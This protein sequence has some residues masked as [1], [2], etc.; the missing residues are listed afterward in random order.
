MYTKKIKV[1]KENLNVMELSIKTK[2]KKIDDL[3]NN[4]SK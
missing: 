1:L 3:E 4:V 2:Q